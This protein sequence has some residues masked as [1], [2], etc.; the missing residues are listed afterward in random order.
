MA[1]LSKLSRF[2]A[3]VDGLDLIGAKVQAGERL[4]S[5][6][7][8]NPILFRD[9][10]ADLPVILTEVVG[11]VAKS[12]VQGRKATLQV[13]NLLSSGNCSSSVSTSDLACCEVS[14]LRLFF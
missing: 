2:N 8:C 9:T 6:T 4:T 14:F 12:V 5:S 11:Y 7:R 1:A 10:D 3:A 13:A